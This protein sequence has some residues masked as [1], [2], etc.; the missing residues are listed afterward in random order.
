MSRPDFWFD[1]ELT[2]QA[3]AIDLS[4]RQWYLLAADIGLGHLFKGEGE[5]GLARLTLDQ[6]THLHE[7]AAMRLVR[8]SR[9]F[10]HYVD[11][12]EASILADP[13]GRSDSTIH[14]LPESAAIGLRKAQVAIAWLR[15]QIDG[16]ENEWRLIAPRV[17]LILPGETLEREDETS[18]EDRK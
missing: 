2:K 14:K 10:V 7:R 8:N 17:G 3:N 5:Y 13:V 18:I 12:V 1:A 15:T 4:P 9:P 6:H 11:A 16:L